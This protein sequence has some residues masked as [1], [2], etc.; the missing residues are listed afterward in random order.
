VH[1]YAELDR[2]ARAIA[3]RLQSLGGKGE[4]VMILLQPGLQFISAYFGCLYA[5]H[6]AIPLYPHLRKKKDNI[7]TRIMNVAKDARPVAVI[8]NTVIESASSQFFQEVEETRSTPWVNLDQLSLA[9]AENWKDLHLDPDEIAFLQYTSGSTN[10]P[11]G[12]MVSHGNLVHN[13]QAIYKKFNANYNSRGVVWLPP[14]HDMGLIGG[15]LEPIYGGFLVYLMPPPYFLQR[16]LRWLEAISRLKTDISGGPNFAYEY[17]VKKVRPEQRDQLDLSHWKTAFSGAEPI[18]PDTLRRFADYFAPCGFHYDNYQP[19]YGLAE[20]TLLVTSVEQ[21]DD[22][23]TAFFNKEGLEKNQIIPTS[24]MESSRELVGCGDVGFEMGVRIV[25]PDTLELCKPNEIGEVWASGGSIAKGY[26]AKPEQSEETFNAH[27]K[28]TG[29]GPFMRTGDLG[30]MRDGQLY[31]TGRIKE[32]I[33]IDGSNHYPQDIEW[34]VEKCH[35]AVRPHGVSAFPVEVDGS[36]KLVLMT[37]IEPRILRDMTDELRREIRRAIKSGVSAEHDLSVHEI[38][39][40]N[41]L[42][43]TTSGKIRH[44]QCKKEFLAMLEENKAG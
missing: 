30:F 7:L 38:V 27:I 22:P 8:S 33:I 4:R 14:Y 28:D 42:P 25:N 32:L 16:P 19:C 17:C 40:V 24:E 20:G 21:T 13:T 39:F 34:T 3:A 37:E 43:R 41:R 31:I 11:K 6:V 35:E 12:V 5:G 44:H 29:E 15:I 9:E 26:W 1:T 18:N 36:E 23:V 2:K 10:V